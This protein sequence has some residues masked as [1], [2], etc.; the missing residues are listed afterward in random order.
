MKKSFFII[1]TFLFCLNSIAQN[2]IIPL[3]QTSTNYGDKE[4]AYYKDMNNFMNQFEGIW[5]YTDGTTTL[6]V[7]LKKL[8]MHHNNTPPITYYE[9]CIIGEYQY[10][11]N[12]VEKVNTIAELSIDK[13]TIYDYNLYGSRRI[14]KLV[15]PKCDDCANDEYR[16]ALYLNE[17]IRRDVL[18][19][20]TEFIVRRVVE[21]GVMILKAQVYTESSSYGVTRDWQPTDIEYFS[22]PDGSYTLVKDL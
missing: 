12:G 11:E 10:V 7:I 22:L 21:N 1:S 13:P 3:Y 18:G 20:S 14:S 6:K 4:G 2:P 19:L 15:Q 8:I 9:D 17:P 16:L 5:L